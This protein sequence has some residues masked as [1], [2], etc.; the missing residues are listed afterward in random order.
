MYVCI[1]YMY[2][3]IQTRR[4]ED[5]TLVSSPSLVVPSDAV[6]KMNVR[7][8]PSRFIA[9]IYILDTCWTGEKSVD[10][11]SCPWS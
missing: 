4:R 1:M 11:T 2:H 3:V 8:L 6:F 10:K 5:R 7:F 9:Y